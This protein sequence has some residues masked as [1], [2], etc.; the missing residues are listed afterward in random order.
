MRRTRRRKCLCCGEL[1]R[2]DRRNHGRQKYCAKSSCRQASKASSQRHWLEKPQNHSYFS[3]PTHVER[4]RTWRAAHPGYWRRGGP[5]KPEPL[6]DPFC[7]Q[8]IEEPRD[9]GTLALQELW[10]SQPAVLVG[11]IAT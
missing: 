5:G 11:L 8:A 6:Q 2:P 1:F 3:G 9:S 4:V 7:A 10:R